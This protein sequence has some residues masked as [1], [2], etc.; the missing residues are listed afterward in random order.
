MFSIEGLIINTGEPKLGRVEIDLTT[1]LIVKV[2]EPTGEADVILQDQLIFPGF[3]DLH[4]HAR[5]DVSHSQDYKEDFVSAG[6]AAINGGVVAFAEMPNNPVP[7]IDDISYQNK[8][9]LT[10][11]SE[12]TVVLYAGIGPNTKPLA[13]LVPYKVFM[14]PSV[15][16]LFFTSKN[17]LENVIA[18]YSGQN[19][20][21]HCEDPEILEKNKN[22]STHILRRP[23]EAETQA[24][25]F[26]LMLIK[27]YNLIGKICHCSTLSGI[28]KIISAKKEGL[29]VTVEVTPTHLFFDSSMLE[30]EKIK[31]LQM[32]PP[33]RQDKENRLGL[34]EHLRLGNIDYLATDR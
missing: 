2:G 20:S 34:I 4:V 1:G 24:I 11:K 22:E 12:V 33:V 13:K 31:F 7:P 21:F 32:N 27:K 26:A 14:G 9:D 10:K 28:E 16:E 23:K 25:D 15:G 3:V 19:V 6:Q 5:E 18:K 8:S 29:A 17:D 30:G